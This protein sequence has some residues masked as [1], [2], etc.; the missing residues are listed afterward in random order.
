MKDSTPLGGL[1]L[2]EEDGFTMPQCSAI[3]RMLGIR[4]GYYHTDS[5][6]CYE[7]DSIV[8]YM[9]D[10][11]PKCSGFLYKKLMG[12]GEVDVSKTDEYMDSTWNKFLP[13]IEARL[14]GHGKP[15]IAGTDRPTIA[16]FKAW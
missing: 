7:I 2:W 16:D 9:E 8:D 13:V 11:V 12:T 1:P 5:Q 4:Y 3:L 10:F 6:I 15:F 14:A